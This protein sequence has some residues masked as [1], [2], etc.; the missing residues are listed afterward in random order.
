VDRVAI[1]IQFF[2]SAVDEE[3]SSSSKKQD[4]PLLLD[5]PTFQNL[6]FFDLLIIFFSASWRLFVARNRFLRSQTAHQ[7]WPL[8]TKKIRHPTA[9]ERK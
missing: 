8:M 1:F 4:K 5:H 7:T 2:S 6:I 9:N 3:K